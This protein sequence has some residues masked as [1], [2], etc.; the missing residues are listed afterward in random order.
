M[1]QQERAIQ[2]TVADICKAADSLQQVYHAS[3]IYLTGNQIRALLAVTEKLNSM[4]SVSVQ[5]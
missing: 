2:S 4:I 5:A 1:T 3:D